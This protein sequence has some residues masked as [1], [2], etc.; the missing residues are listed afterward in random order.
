MGRPNVHYSLFQLVF[1][2]K[3]LFYSPICITCKQ[4]S[5]SRGI[6]TGVVGCLCLC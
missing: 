1:V 4:T 6:Y 2:V 5:T 3:A